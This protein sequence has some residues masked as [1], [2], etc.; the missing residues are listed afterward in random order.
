MGCSIYSAFAVNHISESLTRQ[1][2]ANTI[3]TAAVCIID[4]IFFWV[5]RFETKHTPELCLLMAISASK[6]LRCRWNI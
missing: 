6:L 5:V 2:Q 3:I 1:Q 4:E